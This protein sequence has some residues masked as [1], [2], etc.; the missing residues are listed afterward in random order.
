MEKFP[1]NRHFLFADTKMIS[2][3]AAVEKQFD[4]SKIGSTEIEDPNIVRS[5]IKQIEDST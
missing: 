5:T 2:N 4:K 1:E 3:F